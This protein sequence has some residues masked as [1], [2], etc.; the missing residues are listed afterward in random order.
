MPG[1]FSLLELTVV[2][3]LMLGLLALVWPNLQKPLRRTGLSEAARVLRSAIDDSQYLASLGPEP[4]LLRLEQGRPEIA[5]NTVSR[6]LESRDATGVLSPANAPSDETFVSETASGDVPP[7]RW[8]LPSGVVIRNLDW[9]QHRTP[10]PAQALS[11]LSEGDLEEPSL[12]IDPIEVAEA[13]VSAADFSEPADTL[14]PS[15][16]W[17]PF[18]AQGSPGQPAGTAT[19]ELYDATTMESLTI[20]Y[21]PAAGKVEILP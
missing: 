8:Q 4:M 2:L 14:A 1:G 3:L 6:W 7:R 11:D 13:E 19:I 21:W 18:F 10:P 16:W 5:A 17:L 20:E 9:H 15:I 12:A